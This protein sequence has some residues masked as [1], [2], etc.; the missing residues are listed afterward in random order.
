MNWQCRA[1]AIADAWVAWL[2]A[3]GQDWQQ[4][5]PQFVA[6]RVWAIDKKL[7]D[8]DGTLYAGAVVFAEGKAEAI[9]RNRKQ[10]TY[11]GLLTLAQHYEPPAGA[12]TTAIPNSFVDNLVG[13]LEYIADKLETLTA[14]YQLNGQPANF[15]VWAGDREVNLSWLETSLLNNRSFL[16]FL[17]VTWSEVRPR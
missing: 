12:T 13:T 10:Q 3:A 7:E 2:N 15:Q 14:T 11:S 4:P 17:E 5:A 6:E 9:A 1:A 8:I 16:G